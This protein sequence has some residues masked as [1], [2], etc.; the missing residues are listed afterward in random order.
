MA[1]NITTDVAFRRSR[2]RSNTT[3]GAF[4]NS[5]IAVEPNKHPTR[6]TLRFEISPVEKGEDVLFAVSLDADGIWRVKQFNEAFA[7]LF[8][9]PHG[10]HSDVRQYRLS[11][12]FAT[13]LANALSRCANNSQPIKLDVPVRIGGHVHHWKFR[14]EPAHESGA[15]PSHILCHGTDVTSRDQ[16]LRGRTG[17]R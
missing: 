11:L 13:P 16:T 17:E 12:A 5:I 1:P 9:V 14:L 4:E 3:A 7:K 10:S 15:F 2:H 8:G 6:G